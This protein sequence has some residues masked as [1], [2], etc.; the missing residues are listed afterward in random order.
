MHPLRQPASLYYNSLC[1][2]DQGIGPVIVFLHGW[3]LRKESWQK[4]CN[5]FV[6]KGYRCIAI[7]LPGFGESTINYPYTIARYRDAIISVLDQLKIKKCVLVGHSFGGKCAIMVAAS[8]PEL[9]THLI[10]CSVNAHL[11][12]PTSRSIIIREMLRMGVSKTLQHTF[13]STHQQL[14]ASPL[15]TLRDLP[16]ILIYG[17][18]DFITPPSCGQDIQQI[19]PDATLAVMQRAGH[20]PYGQT[21]QFTQLIMKY[22]KAKN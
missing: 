2:S 8:R 5:E 15:A 22:C 4:T 6:A 10:L 14:Y 9:I 20:L 12:Q 7:D 11:R 17:Q 18:Y 3:N 19:L 21:I 16:T 1:Y 13:D